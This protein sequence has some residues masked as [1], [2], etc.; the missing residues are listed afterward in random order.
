MLN[1]NQFEQI[2]L[3]ISFP[4]LK[5]LKLNVNHLTQFKLGLC[6]MLETLNINDNQLTELTNLQNYPLLTNIDLSFN[7][8]TDVESLFKSFTNLSKEIQ[9]VNFKENPFLA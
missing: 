1:S 9:Y 7:Q 2:N 6:P 5:T 3:S 8:F 4:I